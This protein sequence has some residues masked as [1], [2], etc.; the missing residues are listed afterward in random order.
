MCIDKPD[1]SFGITYTPY[2]GV[3]TSGESIQV[4]LRTG[5]VIRR[6]LGRRVAGNYIQSLATDE[7]V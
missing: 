1:S 2:E 6:L 7:E 5:R 4:D 3:V